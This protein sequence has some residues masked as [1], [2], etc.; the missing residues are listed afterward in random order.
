M[1]REWPL[2]WHSVGSRTAKD[3]L[4]EAQAGV[5]KALASGRRAEIVDLLAQGER[6][7]DDIS[8]E[9]DQSVAN[10]SHH[11]RTLARAGLLQSRREGTRVV[12]RLAGDE[13]G[14]LW[15]AIREVAERHVAGIER[16]T[17]AYL[18][19][20]DGLEPAS[21]EELARRV[22]DGTVVV[23]DVRP[24]PEYAAGHVAGA[25]SMPIDELERELELMPQDID[26]VAYCRGPYCVFAHEAVRALRAHGIAAR[27]LEDGLPEWRRAGMPVAVG[28]GSG[29]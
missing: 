7:V 5:A 8:A 22:H 24:R 15:A 18:G 10:T 29:P 6:S 12:Y 21:R 9:I 25:R 16:L 20:D 2:R 26:V 14:E 17:R 19:G 27:R 11:L 23:I 28:E 3:A 1:Q 4:F 13:V